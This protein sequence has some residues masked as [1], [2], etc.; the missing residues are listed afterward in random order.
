M[1][2]TL[3][4][5]VILIPAIRA[6]GD[7]ASVHRAVSYRERRRFHLR[8]RTHEASISLR[9]LTDAATGPS[10][11]IAPGAARDARRARPARTRSP[12]S[13]GAPTGWPGREGRRCSATGRRASRT[14][15]APRRR[16]RQASPA[17][18]TAA[19][20]V[21]RPARRV[22]RSARARAA[23]GH[24]RAD[25][26]RRRARAPRR[27]QSVGS[28]RSG[29]RWAT[30]PSHPATAAAADA[31]R[32]GERKTRRARCPSSE[33]KRPLCPASAPSASCSA[34]R[35]RS[36]TSPAIC[37]P[38]PISPIARSPPRRGSRRAARASRAFRSCTRR[39]RSPAGVWRWPR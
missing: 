21:G 38:A 2:S 23:S 26:A 9:T 5:A 37:G 4:S 17:R 8:E 1:T 35:S 7:A 39:S 16:A 32:D 18:A 14:T 36:G 13:A 33:P 11:T 25:A 10:N 3:Q 27:A 29:R 28:K 15:A 12:R 6:S 22:P 24:V 20:L 19:R 34:S 31:G 30:V